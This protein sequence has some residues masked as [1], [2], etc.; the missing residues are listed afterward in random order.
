MKQF[1]LAAALCGA[2]SGV[3]LAADS[4]FAGTWKLDTTKSQFTG[5]TLDYS[6]TATGMHYSDGAVAYNFAMD[7]KDYPVMPG[8][9]T[10]WTKTSADGWDMVAKA[11]GKVVVKSHRMLSADGS[12][13]SSAWT[14]YRPDGTTAKGSTVYK[15][16]SGSTGL[17]GKWKD[18]KVQ[19]TDDTMKIMVP[20]VGHYEMVSPAYKSTI[21]GMTDGTPAP[22]KGPTVPP[23]AMA[24]YKAAGM[25]TWDYTIT[26][27]GK[28]Y[29]KGMLTVSPD[30]KTLTDTSWTPGKESEKSMAV[31][32]K[33]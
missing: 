4:P 29:E 16:L 12:T 13:L 19:A 11:D 31:Y 24:S 3:A 1:V 27:Q 22:I 33:S 2:M 5:D 17:A 6:K 15:R 25:G 8:R 9:T 23:G 30:G 14:E 28:A 18:V 20:A 26:V 21:I 32:D 10:S 7:G